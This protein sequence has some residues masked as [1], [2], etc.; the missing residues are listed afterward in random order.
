MKVKIE[1]ASNLV[2]L[3]RL[4]IGTL[5]QNEGQFFSLIIQHLYYRPH[6]ISCSLVR[7][8]RNRFVMYFEVLF[9]VSQKLT[10]LASCNFDIDESMLIFGGHVTE[11]K[12]S[13]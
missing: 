6:V 8:D 5:P 9:T 4:L 2:C 13:N 7:S 11:R 10:H 12:F 3:L 1:N